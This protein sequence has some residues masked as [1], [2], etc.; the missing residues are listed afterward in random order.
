MFIG[1]QKF[2][3]Y[4]FFLRITFFVRSLVVFDTTV[5]Y[6]L[7]VS[8]ITTQNVIWVL[9]QDLKGMQGLNIVPSE[10]IVVQ[11][12]SKIVRANHF[13]DDRIHFPCIAIR[14]EL[15][16]FDLLGHIRRQLH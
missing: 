10:W 7:E 14:R 8:V 13:I 12:P 4:T 1:Y 15:E 11:I 16:H 3:T 6:R 9:F 2:L 5:V